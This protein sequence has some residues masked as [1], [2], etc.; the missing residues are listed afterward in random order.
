VD[1]TDK[2]DPWRPE[3]DTR[4]SRLPKVKLA[5]APSP[6]VA[7][8]EQLCDLI[9]EAEGLRPDRQ[10]LVAALILAANPDGVRLAKLWRAY[11]LALV[12]E[13]VLDL[14]TTEGEVD[15]SGFKK[16]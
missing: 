12:H 14:G 8:T 9:D 13:T 15:L 7:R 2:H 5:D 4:T 10:D 6:V 11:R 3:A 16:R 1:R